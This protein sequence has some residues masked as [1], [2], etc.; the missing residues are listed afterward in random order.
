VNAVINFRVPY[1][2]EIFLT[3]SVTISFSSGTLLHGV[4]K[5][6]MIILKRIGTFL[7]CL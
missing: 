2:A 6:F 3:N 4:N 1:K 7:F 5:P